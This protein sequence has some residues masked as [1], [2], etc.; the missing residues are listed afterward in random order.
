MHRISTSRRLIYRRKLRALLL[1]GLTRKYFRY[2]ISRKEGACLPAWLHAAWCRSKRELQNTTA[3]HVFIDPVKG[4]EPPRLTE[5][6][7]PGFSSGTREWG[8]EKP[9]ICLDLREDSEIITRASCG[10]PGLPMQS[11]GKFDL[12]RE[13]REKLVIIAVPETTPRNVCICSNLNYP[14]MHNFHP[15]K[16]LIILHENTKALLLQI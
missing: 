14:V 13:R 10:V 1:R 7:S 6:K 4:E 8:A 3:R 5:R 9:S 2:Y 11:P 12:W 16:S 15:W